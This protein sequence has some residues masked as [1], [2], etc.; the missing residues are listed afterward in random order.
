MAPMYES[1]MLLLL[2]GLLSGIPS[3]L[4]NLGSYVLTALAVYTV[5]RRRGLSKPW[6]AWVPVVNCWLIGSLADQYRYLVKGENRS[7]RKWLLG[8]KLVL[9]GLAAAVAVMGI[10]IAGAAVF[11]GYRS[12]A[13]LIRNIMGPAVT[14]L[15]LALPMAGV[16][17]AYAVIYFMA[18]Y[19]IYKSMDPDNAV[20]FLVLSVL[21]RITEP[22]FL[23]FNRDKEK[24]MPPR[25]SEQVFEPR[26]A[27]PEQEAEP[28]E[29]EDKDYL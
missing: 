13:Q 9:M 15:G 23:F 10:S 25:K 29:R 7:R 1:N 18:M 16:A 26:Q 8:L 14:L 22:F 20:L 11:G 12:E 19:D 4:L 3:M 21:F 28:W 17:I 24:G 2:S 6:L 5:A 27:F